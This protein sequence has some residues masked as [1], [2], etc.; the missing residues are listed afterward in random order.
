M[1]ITSNTNVSASTKKRSSTIIWCPPTL[2]KLN[3]AKAE[4]NVHLSLI[5]KRTS[6]DSEMNLVGYNVFSRYVKE[7][8]SEHYSCYETNQTWTFSCTSILVIFFCNPFSAAISGDF[9]YLDSLASRW[10]KNEDRT[11]VDSPL[12]HTHHVLT[13]ITSSVS[14]SGLSYKRSANTLLTYMY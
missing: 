11:C 5:H 4:H 3:V 2:Q 7:N 6:S 9:K 10:W 12:C 14:G 1:V 8:H 13:V